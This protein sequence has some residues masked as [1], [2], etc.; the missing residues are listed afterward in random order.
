MNEW[1]RMTRTPRCIFQEGDDTDVYS[2]YPSHEVNI[3]DHGT[4]EGGRSGT[5]WSNKIRHK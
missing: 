4:A 2:P 3:S 1:V 5:V